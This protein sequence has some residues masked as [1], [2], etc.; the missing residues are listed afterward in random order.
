MKNK[1]EY[2]DISDII[3]K[4]L[5]PRLKSECERLGIPQSFI[6]G[7][8]GIYPEPFVR[9]SCCEPIKQGDKVKAVMI[10]IDSEI[11]SP[12][13][14]LMDFWHELRH[15]K[16]CYE[17]RKSSEWRANLYVLRRCLEQLVRSITLR[18]TQKTSL[19]KVWSG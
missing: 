13:I 15:A 6:A 8:Y 11:R 1:A 19:P 12:R 4:H 18:L 9:S 16:D 7:I 17:N 2:R 10:R 3:E 14:V 5:K